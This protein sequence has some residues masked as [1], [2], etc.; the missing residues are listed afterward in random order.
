MGVRGRVD[1]TQAPGASFGQVKAWWF[2]GETLRAELGLRDAKAWQEGPRLH[3]GGCDRGAACPPARHA[4]PACCR[5]RPARSESL[6]SAGYYGNLSR[7]PSLCTE[8]PQR[9]GDSPRGRGGVQA[10]LGVVQEHGEDRVWRSRGDGVFEVTSQSA[11]TFACRERP[12]FLFA[13]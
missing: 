6:A 1:E 12:E 2:E 8:A 5:P 3:R 11:A 9:L 13:L 7:S 10:R 4:L